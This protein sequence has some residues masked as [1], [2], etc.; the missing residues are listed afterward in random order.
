MK[1]GNAPK[2]AVDNLHMYYGFGYHFKVSE[3]FKITPG[4]MYRNTE[5]APSSLDINTTLQFK[6]IDAGMNY[7]VDEMYSIFTM[8]NIIENVKFGAAYDF[9]TSKVNQINDNGSMEIFLKFYL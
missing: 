7:R 9:T 3:E 5:G 1:Q 2:A 8:F 6:T 4:I